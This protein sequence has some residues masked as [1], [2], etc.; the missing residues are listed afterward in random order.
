MEGDRESPTW[1]SAKLPWL[2]WLYEALYCYGAEWPHGWACLV[3]S[4]WSLAKDGQGLQ[5]LL[6]MHCCP[7]LQEVFRW[8][9]SWSKKNVSITFPA[10]VWMALEFFLW[11]WPWMLPL[12]TLSFQ[13]WF[14]V[15]TPRFLSS[16][17][18]CQELFPFPGIALRGPYNMLPVV[19][20][21]VGHPLGT[22]F[23]PVQSFRH[24]GVNTSDAQ[25]NLGGYGFHCNS[26]VL[27]NESLNQLDDVIG[28]AVWCSR[29]CIIS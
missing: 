18:S 24:D 3:I 17:H 29:P 13:F 16:H 22:H 9:P 7:A 25:S 6:G 28:N 5:V 2:C 12:E 20:E 10:L 15:M 26:A 27:G 19:I 1:I 14:K 23:A 4:I 8:G 21:Y 11:W